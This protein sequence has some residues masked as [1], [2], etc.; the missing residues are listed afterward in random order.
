MRAVVSPA[1][2]FDTAVQIERNGAAF[3]RKAAEFSS[4]KEQQKRLI[5]LAR[6]EDLH[7]ASFARLKNS[8]VGSAQEAERID[9]DGP[10]IRY[11]QAFAK[12]GI[13]NMT[14]DAAQALSEEPTMRDLLDFAIEREKD[15][16]LFYSGI[17]AALTKKADRDIVDAIVNEELMHLVVLHLEIKGLQ[18]PAPRLR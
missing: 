3:Y 13:F 18:P 16:V 15:S 5:E 9:P 11:L 1:K 12:E 6:A 7:A 10:G 8:L 4:K 14:L 2:V 17:R